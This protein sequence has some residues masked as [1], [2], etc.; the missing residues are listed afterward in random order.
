[1][2]FI[3]VLFLFANA[4]ITQHSLQMY[5]LTSRRAHAHAHDEMTEPHLVGCGV[6]GMERVGVVKIMPF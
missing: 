3:K 1:M 4:T 6:C 5:R 2:T